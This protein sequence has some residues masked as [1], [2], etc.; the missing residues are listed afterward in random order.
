MLD[1][2]HP[3][4]QL[5]DFQQAEAAWKGHTDF[6][7]LHVRKVF[8]FYALVSRLSASLQC[9]QPQNLSARMSEGCDIIPADA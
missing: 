3:I 1:L 5:Q 2:H 6:T 9:L 7:C 8:P 4:E